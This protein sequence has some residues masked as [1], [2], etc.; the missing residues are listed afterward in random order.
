MINRPKVVL[1][2]EIGHRVGWGHVSRCLILR[3]ILSPSFDV[4]LKIVNRE[5]WANPE[6]EQAFALQHPVRADIAF[7]DGL[8]LREELGLKVRAGAVASLSYMSDVN[9]V[10][11]LVVAPALNG[12]DV[13]GHFLTDLSAILCNRPKAIAGPH[14]RNSGALT[15]GISMG[16]A[17]VEGLTPV[18]ERALGQSGHRILTMANEAGRHPT[19]SH[20]LEHKLYDHPADPFP[21]YVF[22]E[23]D[24]VV[25]Q[26]GLSAIEIALLGIPTVIR[27]RS[28]FTPAY[29]FLE[30][31]GCSRRSTGSSIAELENTI[32]FVC[33]NG[34]QRA[35]MARACRGLEA[36]ID[37]SFWQV[38]I[39]QLIKKEAHH[40]AMPFLRGH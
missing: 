17:D 25:C 9:D 4:E 33:D 11:D 16:G 37:E 21:Y 7:V 8:E 39:Y 22:S 29:R 13:P 24:L 23:C 19:L 40:E 2:A 6:L 28:D 35:E 15:I 1:I 3:R 10:V 32:N 20:F 31:S 30:L 36:E 12:M 14:D 38:L 18:L 27:S 5:G 26:G 34:G